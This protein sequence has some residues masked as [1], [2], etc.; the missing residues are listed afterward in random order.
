M[1]RR[2]LAITVVVWQVMSSG[3]A[4]AQARV[5][6]FEIG[7]QIMVMTFDSPPAVGCASDRVLTV[8][9]WNQVAGW[10]RRLDRLRRAG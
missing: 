5:D 7:G 6:R 3:M 9:S 2:A 1:H 4:F 8:A 10:L